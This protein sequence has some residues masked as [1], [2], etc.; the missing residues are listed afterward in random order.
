MHSKQIWANLAVD[1]I[2][3]TADFYNSLGIQPNGEPT[4]ELASF[5]FAENSLV[6]H[7]FTKAKLA[8]AFGNAL[9]AGTEVM[10][11]LAAESEADVSEWLRRAKE[12]GGSIFR[13]PGRDEDGYYY[14]GFADPDGHKFNV[15]LIEAGM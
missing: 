6:I 11:S 14:G 9:T 13:E 10:F 1:D 2:A 12:A 7:F 15:L 8:S 4:R 5:V 3:R